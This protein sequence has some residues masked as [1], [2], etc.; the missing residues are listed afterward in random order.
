MSLIVLIGAQAVGKMTVG[1]ELEKQI[2]GKL[3][4][5]HQTIDLY[6]NFLG[7]TQETF[8]LSD[9]TRRELFK[10][11]V[12]N[13]NNNVTEAIIFTIMIGF[14]EA[15][16]RQFL[17]EIAAIFLDAG[18]EVYFVELVTDLETRIQRNVGDD[19]LAAKP[20]KRDIAFSHHEL[21]TSNEKWRLV[22]L[23]NEL[24]TLEPR[25]KTLIIDNTQLS[26]VETATKIKETFDL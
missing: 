23:P 12:L 2:D 3:L 19:R 17:K 4:Y 25:A 6:A 5:N 14:S 15:Y 20:S 11:F 8:R 16:D 7:Y 24:A 22:S 21:I 13:K 1:K 18:E 26:P 9:L 10:S